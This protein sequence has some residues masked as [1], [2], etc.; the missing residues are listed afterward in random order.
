[1]I[2]F[3][4][5]GFMDNIYNSYFFTEFYKEN[6]GGDYRDESI[7]VPFFEKIA[8]KI[9]EIW[10][11]KR[12]LDAGCAYG[13]LVSSLRD[14]GV[15]AYGI[16]ISTFAVGKVR[17]DVKSYCNV[18]SITEALPKSFPE[19]FDL[20]TCIEVLEHLYTE[21]AEKAVKNLCGYTNTIIFSSTPDDV[22]DQTHVNVQLAEY[23]ARLYASNSF[24]KNVFQRMEWLSPWAS[25]YVKR[26]DVFNV[27]N[28]YERKIRILEM[29]RKAECDKLECT[30]Q[31][32]ERIIT[33]IKKCEEKDNE[34]DA[35]MTELQKQSQ[36]YEE[37]IKRELK[38]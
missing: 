27:I 13:Y 7:W 28:E 33:E 9:I 5:E 29:Q 10:N 24:Y 15:E 25:V 2:R 11:P 14:R 30:L 32:K 19:K 21:D 16:D 4:E 12:V 23:W 6:G 37:I 26:Q 1:M 20:I 18:Q 31:E 34:N 22:K 35:Q 38:K 17:D 3:S 36:Y 8:D